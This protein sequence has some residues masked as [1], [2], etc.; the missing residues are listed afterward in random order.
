MQWLC[1]NDGNDGDGDRNYNDDFCLV[2]SNGND[3]GGNDGC[4]DNDNGN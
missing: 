4:T 1:D 2:N 3:D